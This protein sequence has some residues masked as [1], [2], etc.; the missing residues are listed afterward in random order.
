M[1]ERIRLA[2]SVAALALLVALS[3]S[4]QSPT[5]LSGT[6]ADQTGAVIVGVDV[7]LT[8]MPT[9]TRLTART[10]E[11]GFY[12]FPSLTPGPYR[13][14]VEVRGFQRYESEL[15]LGAGQS[16][17]I[18]PV[19]VPGA[20]T[21]TIEVRDVTPLITVDS[22]T[23]GARLERTRIE[24]LPINGRNLATLLATQ[25]G[26][27]GARTFGAPRDSYDWLV[28]G[29]TINDRR[30]GG[31]PAMAVPLESVQEFAL[32]ANAVSAKNPRPV[33][34][35][36]VT[37]SGTNAL[38]GS[39]FETHRNNAI[40]LARARTDYYQK[41]PPLIRNEFGGSAGGP[42]V[43]PT[44]YNGKDRTFWFVTA[45]ALIQRQSATQGYRVP[46]E[47]M[48]KGD[49]SGL[50][51]A[52]GR[53]YVIYDPWTTNPVP[54][55]WSRQPFTYGGQLNRI[56]PA[57]I[58]P[59]AK[60]LFDII[61]L[62]THPDNPMVA[63]NWWGPQ[64]TLTD[65]WGV[66][67][68]FD[69]SFGD[70]SRFYARWNIM[71][72]VT[73][74][75]EYDGSMQLLNR[76][77]GWERRDGK[78]KSIVIDYLHTIS[79]TFFNELNFGIYRDFFLDSQGG[80]VT[81]INW[82][83]KLN[84]PNPFRTD[85]WP[86]FYNAGF[87]QYGVNDHKFNAQTYSLLKNDA[88]KLTGKHEL[89]FGYQHRYEQ[90][91]ILPQQRFAQPSVDFAT[92]A[93]A[94]YDKA[95]PAANPMALSFTG[96]NM[97]NFF[98]GLG[99]YSA[100]QSHWMYYLR[101]HE[102]ALYLQDTHKVTR[103]LTLNLGLRWEYW[104]PY[105]DKNNVVVGM[106]PKTKAV[107][108]GVD[109]HTLFVLGQSLPSIWREYEALGMKYETW[110]QAG[111]PR[112]LAYSRKTNFGPRLGFAYRALSGRQSF[113]LRGGY[114]LSYFAP[115]TYRWL[116]NTNYNAPLR[117]T[118]SWNPNSTAQA[119]DGLPLYWMRSVP[120][121][122]AGVNTGGESVLKLDKPVGI[123]RGAARTTFWDPHLPDSRSHSVNL[124]LEKELIRETVARVRYI[125]TF[126]RNLD[127]RYFMNQQTPEY[128]WY[129][130]TG[131]PLPT[132]EYGAVARRPFDNKI[133]GQV[134]EYRQDGWSNYHGISAEVEKRYSNGVAFQFS[135]VMG[136]ALAAASNVE[137]ANVYMPGAVPS[138]YKERY[139]FLNYARE[140]EPP[141]HRLRW[142]WLIDLP[143]GRGKWLGRNAGGVLN[144]IIGGWQIAGIGT[145]RS[146]YWSLGTSHWN[147]TGVPIQIYG[148]K[149]PIQDCTSGVCYPAYLYWNGYIPANKIN[150]VD[151]A[152]GRPNGYMGIP[153]DYKPA[154]TPL[155]P[156]G[157][158]T[159]P[160]NA[161]P[162][163]NIATF[164]D[165]NNVWV[166]LKNGTVQRVAYNTNLHPW[167]NQL[168]PGHFTWDQ[169]ASLFKEV[170]IKESTSL[171]FNADFFNVFNMPGRPTGVSGTTGVLSMRSS[172]KS[173]RI[174][175]LG[176]RLV[177]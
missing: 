98:L 87:A 166:P 41:A 20:T 1:S 163:T 88:T 151:P 113:V 164:W 77:S 11:A 43:L 154:V 13:L 155:I 83:D 138:D 64:Q 120:Q 44:L 145:A 149:Y 95:S 69:H 55:D 29:I 176:L 46:T 153:P 47:A 42:L 17:V 61:P 7:S 156:W 96:H 32:E 75:P 24:Q 15:T 104:S 117:A 59:V 146:N 134:E 121:Y 140:T 108:A 16:A 147:F 73:E 168:M 85:R 49:M 107:L 130:T 18:D 5:R 110:D 139:R 161:P 21:T 31:A 68:R 35:T 12:L 172:Q 128:I 62:P 30:W 125:G 122:V 28:D 114:S 148:F 79:P 133:W 63:N 22:P 99:N 135:Y 150:S 167:R 58:S 81:G 3:A 119:P 102:V 37:K 10:N 4:A 36:V 9:N 93:T 109:L 33:N 115:T 70:R 160:P 57:R 100:S 38:H 27:E 67:G 71:R 142:N 8:H 56:D 52:Q 171:R 86:I 34:I 173:P 40:G 170:K 53:L 97:A 25:P 82:P 158:T 84:L 66:T 174:T 157:T 45:E 80:G 51:D 103:R 112:S 159:L 6:V 101:R 126:G 50:I 123:T 89:Q 91:N 39:L 169:S 118:F 124:T 131:E 60:Y 48:R 78:R 111:Y 129:V 152:T 143:F 177:F 14:A 76:V 137:S 74:L 116:D 127:Y 90:M 92:S 105:M 162:G 144:K 26:Y 2:T 54:G 94:L 165:T 23:V 141:K 19:L 136:N 72:Q 132:G 175:Q 65:N 106:N